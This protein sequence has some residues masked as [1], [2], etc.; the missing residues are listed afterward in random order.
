MK[1]LVKNMLAVAALAVATQAAAQ[2]T[3]YQREDFAGR[4]FTTDKQV[5]NFGRAGFND[6]ASSVVVS[7]GQWEVCDDADFRGTC[8]VLRPGRYPSLATFS[9]NNNISSVRMVSRNLPLDDSRYVPVPAAAQI[10]F[11]ER[12]GFAG[13]SFT[14][15][16][17]VGNFSRHGFNDRASSVVV[18]HDFWEACEDAWFAGRCVVLRPGRYASLTAMGLGD[19]ISSVRVVG[20]SEHLD[21]SR[22]APPPASVPIATVPQITFYER[23][24]FK[25]RTFVTHEQIDNLQRY[26]Y[27]DRASSAV[28]VGEPREVC[29]GER[30]RGRCAV[31]QPGSYPTLEAMGLNDRISSVRAVHATTRPDNNRFLPL[32]VTATDYRRLHNERLYEARVTSVRA[33]VGRP[34]QRCWV[35]REQVVRDDSS[36]N[37]P[38]A[39][40]GAIIGGILGH[41][42]GGGRGKDFAT[43]G[44]A[45]AGAAVG[46]NIDRDSNGQP[47]ATQDIRRCASVSGPVRADYWDVTYEFQR[48]EYRVQLTSPPGATITVNEQGE[49]RN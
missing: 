46:A 5:S 15:A 25:G 3:F 10:T 12:E 39:I 49:P 4:S 9:M 26:G 27:N 23:E 11:Y 22:F 21:E 44:G 34:E 36:A 24:G 41:Q 30:F 43:A 20:T 40:A 48:Q 35:E 8:A 6:R 14:T 18:Q 42:V 37:V 1:K 31:L 38:A 47:V 32:P 2:I 7:R 19:N 33:V 29:D 16:T 45:I 17:Q 13:R 28:V